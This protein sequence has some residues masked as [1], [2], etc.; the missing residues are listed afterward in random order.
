MAP[1]EST[2]LP[3]AVPT[4]VSTS[5]PTQWHGAAKPW[6]QVAYTGVHRQFAWAPRYFQRTRVDFWIAYWNP[7]PGA[8]L[9][10][11]ER[12]EVLAHHQ[13]VLV[14][15]GTWFRRQVTAPFDHWWAHF[16]V[17]TPPPAPGLIALPATGAL[18]AQLMRVW[19]LGWE[20]GATDARTLAAAHGVIALAL[21]E[22]NWPAP[23]PALDPALAKLVA[24]LTEAG[25][26][27]RDNDDLAGELAMHP[28]SFCRYFQRFMGLSPQAWLRERRL[29][30]A[31]AGLRAGLSV[32]AVAAAGE[33]TDRFHLTRLFRRRFGVGPGFYR[34][35]YRVDGAR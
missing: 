15:P 31:A 22:V 13:V 30:R 12:T 8:A 3:A 28:K 1:S 2:P 35:A 10:G 26:P 21:Q 7:T 14:P 16:H 11:D 9:A 33:F 27:A 18:G 4:P 6:L 32:E 23:P 17:A 5:V 25:Y 24:G 34:E 29:E 19:D 20:R